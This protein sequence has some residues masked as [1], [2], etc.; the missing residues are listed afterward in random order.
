MTIAEQIKAAKAANEQA[1]KRVHA[2]H[3]IRT[4]SWDD[5]CDIDYCADCNCTVSNPVK[6]RPHPV[7]NYGRVILGGYKN[8]QVRVF[9]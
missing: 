3:R 7:A 2:G 9:R 4:S 5:I 6:V 1:T 8:Q